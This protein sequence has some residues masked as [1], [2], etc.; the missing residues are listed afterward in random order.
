MRVFHSHMQNNHKL[1]QIYT[2]K[3]FNITT[4]FLSVLHIECSAPCLQSCAG[5]LSDPPKQSAPLWPVDIAIIGVVEPENAAYSRRN[6]YVLPL[7]LSLITKLLLYLSAPVTNYK[8]VIV[9]VCACE[10]DQMFVYGQHVA[11][12][13]PPSSRHHSDLLTPPSLSWW[14]L[15]MLH[16]QIKFHKTWN[17]YSNAM[18]PSNHRREDHVRHHNDMPVHVGQAGSELV[19]KTVR[20]VLGD[21]AFWSGPHKVRTLFAWSSIQSPSFILHLPLRCKLY[22]RHVSYGRVNPF[23]VVVCKSIC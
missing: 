17:Y 15:K 21:L 12:Q 11:Y 3:T 5:S 23:L 9:P 8:V 19:R 22:R 13:S 10:W 14:N 1:R 16:K 6:W 7:G 4:C 20:S 2:E 18:R